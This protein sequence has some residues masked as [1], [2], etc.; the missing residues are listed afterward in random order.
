MKILQNFTIA[1][2]SLSLLFSAR[3]KYLSPGDI[4]IPSGPDIT[5]CFPAESKT[6]LSGTVASYKNEISLKNN[7]IFFSEVK[8]KNTHNNVYIL[9]NT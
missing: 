1:S 7:T 4:F 9:D 3:S 8:Y 5:S 6:L 2:F